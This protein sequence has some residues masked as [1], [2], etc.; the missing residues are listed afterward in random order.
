M[1]I[2]NLGNIASGGSGKPDYTGEI[3]GAKTRAGIL[4]RSTQS[5]ITFAAV[6]QDV[7]A[8]PSSIPWVQAPLAS[9]TT[10]HLYETSSGV[11]MP[12]TVSEGYT[13]TLLQYEW[14][15]SQDFE[16]W[17]YLDTV[18]VGCAAISPPGDNQGWNMCVMFSTADFDPVGAT[19]HTLDFTIVNTGL[20]A[21]EGS[22]DY[23]CIL[24]E[25]GS[26]PLPSVKECRCP[27]CGL[28]TQAP[29][30]ESIIKC[31]HCNKTY[32]VHTVKRGSG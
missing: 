22:I 28:L 9:G 7:E 8:P 24:E 23:V 26:P 20:E 3:S 10:S 29:V 11:A 4:L 5:L 25:V 21:L 13:L 19:S 30:R 14:A 31:S 32:H 27:Y 15:I 16:A 2:V 18:L 6:F 12:Y 1:K 17:M